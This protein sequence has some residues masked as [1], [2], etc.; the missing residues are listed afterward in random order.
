M[1]WNQIS[2]EYQAPANG[3]APSGVS[4]KIGGNARASLGTNQDAR[5]WREKWRHLV[6][7]VRKGHETASAISGSAHFGAK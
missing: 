7:V 6:V 1:L 3:A 4:S 5:F 2:R